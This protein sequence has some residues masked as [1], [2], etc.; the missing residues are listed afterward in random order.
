MEG[1]AVGRAWAG[2][3]ASGRGDQGEAD[4]AAPLAGGD[5]VCHRLGR[6]LATGEA[7]VASRGYFDVEDRPPIGA[8]IALIVPAVGGA[9]GA[10]GDDALAIA[11]WVE[12]KEVERARAG[13]RACP[14]GAVVLLSELAPEI[15]AQ[16]RGIEARVSQS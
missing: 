9:M 15:H 2:G 8:W 12:A 7:E 1:A 5:W 11:A 14:N 13:S 16:L 3:G 4:R 10:A 6:S